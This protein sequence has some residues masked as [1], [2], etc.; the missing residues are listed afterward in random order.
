MTDKKELQSDIDTAR[1]GQTAEEPLAEP[2]ETPAETAGLRDTETGRHADA[3]PV[4]GETADGNPAAEDAAD[5]ETDR[6]D[7]FTFID[8]DSVKDR[9]KLIAETE[10]SE[11][12]RA[13][14]LKHAKTARR[15][16]DHTEYR[17]LR[18]RRFL[19]RGLPILIVAAAAACVCGVFG[20]KKYSAYRA[21]Q[22]K[23][24]QTEQKK[25]EQE[26]AAKDLVDQNITA[27]VTNYLNT[28]ASGDTAT[29]GT[30][31]APLSDSEKS[32]IS[33]DTQ[34]IDGYKDVSCTKSRGTADNQ[35][36]VTAVYNMAMK[37]ASTAY[38]GYSYFI[39]EKN[40]QGAY[41]INNR[42]S[43]YNRNYPNTEIDQNV[44]TAFDK[45]L[46]DNQKTVYDAIAKKQGEATAADPT[47]KAAIDAKNK[48]DQ[49]WLSATGNGKNLSA[50]NT[51]A[52]TAQQKQEQAKKV[53]LVKKYKTGTKVYPIDNIVIRKSPSKKGK[54]LATAFANEGLYLLGQ[55]KN[56]WFY[57][58]TGNVTGYVNSD[59]VVGR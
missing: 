30:Y 49:A 35:Y 43:L 26:Q 57:I 36:F 28:Y 24:Q 47:L 16:T 46:A 55:T 5:A 42:Y 51:A 59:Y 31:A 50:W 44:K 20:W 27:V 37:N 18:R 4:S 15:R 12:P 17:I 3:E 33:A 38:P 56:G 32:Y 41:I 22:E 19:R 7:D 58:K 25:Q 9:S 8:T 11:E 40:D 52:G 29:L 45:Y 14:E 10:G 21:G 1:N 6:E 53:K 54:A 34:Y 39:I 23:I 48:V 13:E 2:S